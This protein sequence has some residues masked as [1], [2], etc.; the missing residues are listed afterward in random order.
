MGPS[1]PGE[2]RLWISANFGGGGDLN[3]DGKPDLTVAGGSNVGILLGNGDGTFAPV[4]YAVASGAPT[5]VAVGDFNGDGR[6]D[7][8]F[9]YFPSAN[10]AANFV[11]ILLGAGPP[12]AIAATSGTPQSTPISKAF[13]PPFR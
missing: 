7:L 9:T 4:Y 3:G 10:S 11:N 1:R 5:S 13:R 12:T 6:A 8:A 2:L